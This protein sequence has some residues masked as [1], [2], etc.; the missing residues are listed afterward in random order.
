MLRKIVL[1]GI[2]GVLLTIS[3]GSCLEY[4]VAVPTDVSQVRAAKEAAKK[5][6][7]K[8]KQEQKIYN[9]IWGIIQKPGYGVKAYTCIP[10]GDQPMQYISSVKITKSFG[11]RLASLLTL[12]FYSPMTATWECSQP[13]SQEGHLGNP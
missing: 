1:H 3:L 12:G 13:P 5:D 4:S 9:L 6:Q 8:N 10:P 11:Q 7:R 2:L